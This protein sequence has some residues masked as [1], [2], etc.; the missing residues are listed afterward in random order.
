M[1]PAAQ[2]LDLL[3]EA[4][5]FVVRRFL[6]ARQCA[7]LRLEARQ[8]FKESATISR[9]QGEVLVD[10]G[11]RRTKRA[12]VSR[13]A[14][15]LVT[16]RLEALRPR[17]A[18]HFGVALGGMQQAQFLVYRQGDFFRPH[19]DSSKDPRLGEDI[20]G[21]RVSLVLFLNAQSHLP[22]PEAYCGGALTFYGLMSEPTRDTCRV[23]LGGEE[24]LLV[25]FRSDVIHEVRPVMHGERFTVV[26]W[27]TAPPRGRAA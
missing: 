2:A 15:G 17:L 16:R 6:D 10:E 12:D 3:E 21:R 19:V 27:Y 23:F 25:A 14:Q 8:G 13:A 22:A 9:S 11:T 20:R 7:R 24:G 5:L 4:G 1:T 26:T 18:R